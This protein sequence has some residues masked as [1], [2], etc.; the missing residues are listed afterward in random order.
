ML[1]SSRGESQIPD[2]KKNESQERQFEHVV[3]MNV[4][5]NEITTNGKYTRTETQI[6]GRTTI[7]K[8]YCVPLYFHLQMYNVCYQM[9]V[10]FPCV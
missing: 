5:A 8:S 3:I 6:N 10:H 1:L 4:K 2:G 7:L 9:A